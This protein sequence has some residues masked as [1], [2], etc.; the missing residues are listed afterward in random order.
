[1]KCNYDDNEGR[2]C[3]ANDGEPCEAC[4]AREREEMAYWLRKWE[5]ATAEERD[6]E[7]YK[8]GLIDCGRGH[9][10]KP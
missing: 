9:L 5:V 7:G 4:A 10:V 8:Q 3:T 2:G 6:P 1:M